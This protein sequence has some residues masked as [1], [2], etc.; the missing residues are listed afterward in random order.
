MAAS[1]LILFPGS[2]PGVSSRLAGFGGKLCS[3]TR[4]CS[5]GCIK[6]IRDEGNKFRRC[7][8]YSGEGARLAVIN[9][10]V[11][12]KE[13]FVSEREE[14]ELVKEAR[15]SFRRVKYEYD[16]WDGVI[17]GYRETEKSQWRSQ[18][19]QS[20][21]K[22][23]EKATLEASGGE[24][25][26][27]AAMMNNSPPNSLLLSSVHV[28]DLAKDGYI[29]PH[30]DNV[31]FCGT[32]IAG[33]SLLSD[34]VMK[35]VHQERKDDWILMLLPQRSLYILRDL[36]RYEYEHQILPDSLSYFNNEHIQRDNRISIIARTKP[37]KTT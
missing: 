7:I 30:I 6:E 36:A 28:L 5:G 17:K 27:P 33:I 4:F 21:I 12:V 24:V 20:V 25:T 22:R 18:S 31:K 35:L 13:N 8:Q 29:N 3:S 23:L 26:A 9:E 10:G 37:F 14:E 16:H 2:F 15:S 32:T 34:S 1:R 11:L 19:N